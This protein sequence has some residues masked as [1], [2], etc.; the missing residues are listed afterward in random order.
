[1]KFSEI[2]SRITGIST[3]IIGVSWQPAKPEVVAARRVT[4]FLEDR[5]VLYAPNELEL[6]SHCVESVLQIRRFLTSEIGKLDGKSEL[7]ASLR[8][9][10]AACRK[11]LDTVATNDRDIIRYARQN[12]HYA[13]W[14]FYSAL[15]EMRGVFGVH[16]ARIAVRFRLDIEDDL[17]TILPAKAEDTGE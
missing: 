11:F 4:A 12:G 17:A 15:G 3:P 8:A 9:I 14:T 13:S 6:P 10:R 7:A 1:L 16:L 2:A 5:R